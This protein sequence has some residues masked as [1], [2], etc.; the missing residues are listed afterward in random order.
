MFP[1]SVRRQGIN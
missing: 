1:V